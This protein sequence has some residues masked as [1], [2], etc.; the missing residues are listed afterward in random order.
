MG[1][2]VEALPLISHSLPQ[3]L[4]SNWK[5][6]VGK[7]NDGLRLAVR[8][9]HAGQS[10]SWH[11]EAIH[12]KMSVLVRCEHGLPPVNGQGIKEV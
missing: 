3:A 11:V 12:I 4:R 6:S 10:D 1:D 7:A 9:S 8:Q 5:A 2:F